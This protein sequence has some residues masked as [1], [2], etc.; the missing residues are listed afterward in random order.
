MFRVHRWQEVTGLR[1]FLIAFALVILMLIVPSSANASIAPEYSFPITSIESDGQYARI[2]DWSQITFRT[3]PP[4][5]EAGEFVAPPDLNQTVGYDLSRR[6]K[7]GQT[8][9]SYSNLR[10]NLPQI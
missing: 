2:P 6:W 3:L 8:A 7:A 10:S 1:A 5:L 9:D 4:I